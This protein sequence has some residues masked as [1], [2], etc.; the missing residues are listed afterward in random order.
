MFEGLD[1]EQRLQKRRELIAKY[2][3][4]LP[5]SSAPNPHSKLQ[6]ELEKVRHEKEKNEEKE[7]EVDLGNK[8][9]FKDK[10]FEERLELRRK[11]IDK[12]GTSLATKYHGHGEEQEKKKDEELNDN[13]ELNEFD[14]RIKKR[15]IIMT[16]EDKKEI[17]KSKL[18]DIASNK[19]EYVH[20][21]NIIIDQQ[22]DVYYVTDKKLGKRVTYKP[23][24]GTVS[25]LNNVDKFEGS[26]SQAVERTKDLKRSK[27]PIIYIP[28]DRKKKRFR[29]NELDEMKATEM[30][31]GE[32]EFHP[33]RRRV[34]LGAYSTPPVWLVLPVEELQ[35]W[36]EQSRPDVL[37]PHFLY[38][39]HLLLNRPIWQKHVDRYFSY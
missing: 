5:P 22:G 25:E 1:F 34:I 17:E 28:W 19:L 20:D 18:N 12:Y 27:F 6:E 7:A 16:L 32:R 29:A 38:L 36:R 15:R 26:F 37:D 4:S 3:T 2:G 23:I 35:A 30:L 9:L 14:L 8:D 11:L 31:M 21:P 13:G 33:V 10:N 24:P 39:N